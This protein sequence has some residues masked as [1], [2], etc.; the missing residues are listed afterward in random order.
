MIVIT[1]KNLW[2]TGGQT[3][4]LLISNSSNG[5]SSRVR[6]FSVVLRNKRNR[7]NKPHIKGFIIL[8]L[9]PPRGG[10]R[11][12]L[13]PGPSVCLSVRSSVCQLFRGVSILR[14]N[15]KTTGQNRIKLSTMKEYI[16]KLCTWVLVVRPKLV[17]YDVVKNADARCLT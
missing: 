8:V 2:T 10:S 11:G 4:P 9:R 13:D 15:S 12:L 6:I 3:V 14:P 7:Y 16:L 5:A 1:N 17:S